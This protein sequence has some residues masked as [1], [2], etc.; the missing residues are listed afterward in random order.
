MTERHLSETVA[1]RDAGPKAHM[2]VFTAC[3]GKVPLRHVGPFPIFTHDRFQLC[4]R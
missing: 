4:F 1:R 3:L 2:D